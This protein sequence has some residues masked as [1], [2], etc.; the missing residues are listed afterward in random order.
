MK[1]RILYIGYNFSPELTGIGKYSGEMMEWLAKSGHNCSVITSYPYYPQWEVQEPYV[2]NK[3]GFLKEVIDYSSGGKL[4][5]YRCPMYVPKKPSGLTRIISDFSFFV[6]AL[7]QLI[8]F[9]FKKKHGYVIT[10]APTF[11]AG[12]LG[13][14]YKI[15]RNAKHLHHIQD[16]QIEAAV[17][18]GMI[19]SPLLIKILFKIENFNFKNSDHISSISDAMIN[20]ITKKTNRKV[21]FLPNWSDTNLFYPIPNKLNL[22]TK[23][24][25]SPKDTIVLYSGGIGEKQGLENILY[26]AQALLDFPHV[27]IIICGSGPY[28]ETLKLKAQEMH[29]QNL[30]FMPLQPKEDFND[31]LNMADVHLVIQKK[32]ASDL[33]MPSKLTTILAVGGAALVTANEGTDLHHIVSKYEM[34]HLI[35]AEDRD[36]LTAGIIHLTQTQELDSIKENAHMYAKKYL[37]I[38]TIMQ[39]LD[40]DLL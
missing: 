22:K 34:G 25:F 16:L 5:V 39:S 1:K 13:A 12:V 17:E 24:G 26:A 19:K 18:L 31:F 29:L 4:T 33:V 23:F 35:E 36:A 38:D 8:V 28:K 32:N 15:T 7:L 30:S 9:F 20:R 40:K 3:F 11:L 2:K 6:L 10:V 21:A 37:N 27:K 14:L